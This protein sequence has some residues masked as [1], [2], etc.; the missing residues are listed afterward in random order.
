MA[1]SVTGSIGISGSVEDVR[2]AIAGAEKETGRRSLAVSAAW[3]IAAGTAAGLADKAWSGTRTVLTGATDVIDLN[4]LLTDAFGA[5]TTFVKLRAILIAAALTN[6]TTLQIARPAAATGVPL[7][8]ATSDALAA[9]SAGGF[10]CWCDP[11]AGVTVTASTGDILNVINSGG[12][13]AMYDVLIAGT[14][15]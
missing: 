2:T 8:A 5:V 15:A 9:L 10:F 12:G 11:N 13:T 7:F 4:A 14:S 3:S 1:V 6:T